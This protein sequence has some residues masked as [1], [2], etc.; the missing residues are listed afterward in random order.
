MQEKKRAKRKSS[1][2]KIE[3]YYKVLGVRSN[4]TQDSIK[5]KYIEGV[6]SF[7]PET[8]PEQ[9]QQIRKA[10]ETLK[11]PAKRKE[12]DM[13]R[14]YGDKLDD[15]LEKA[16]MEMEAGDWE[17]AAQ[18]Y[19]QAQQINP[20][21]MSAC[22][23]LAHASLLMGDEESFQQQFRRGLELASTDEEK[24]IV[25]G[26]KARLLLEEERAEDALKELDLLASLYPDHKD[27]LNH[28]YIAVYMELDRSEEAWV[29]ASSL[30]PDEQSQEPED[31]F[32]FISWM[33][34]LIDAE[35]WN[36]W[37]KVQTRI[38]KFLKTI[39]DEDDKLM[40][41]ASLIR[42][43]MGYY[44]VGRFREAD[45]FMDLIYYV[46]S[47]HSIVQMARRET[48]E[49]ARMQ[50]EIGRLQ[51][52]DSIIPIISIHAFEWFYGGFLEPDMLYYMRNNVPSYMLEQM[53]HMKEELAAGVIRLKKKYPVV[54][55][56][57]QDDWDDMYEDAIVG[58]NREAR[59]RLK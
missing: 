38:K 23:G 6:R 30:V 32:S 39:Q 12:Y 15:I 45:M 35:K 41:T 24:V 46:D 48:Q 4:A 37:G 53:M 20:D 11:D 33:N 27:K 49:A 14:K 5:K 44:G 18:L 10:Y 54:Y 50:K 58:L 2:P 7:P 43:Y 40:V 3:N 36:L 19:R 55:K 25:T 1:K 47:K 26:N 57:F 8:H 29:L 59:R 17:Q 31:I 34:A 52:D 16:M 42:E 9:F 22:L 51:E 28:L 56:A 13:L 21:L